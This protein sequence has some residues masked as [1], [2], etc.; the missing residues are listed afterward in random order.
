[1]RCQTA[2]SSSCMQSSEVVMF[3][4]PRRTGIASGRMHTNPQRM[5][6]CAGTANP[7]NGAPK[8]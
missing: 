7:I 6:I 5:G 1:M 2:E 4:I 8:I 3:F